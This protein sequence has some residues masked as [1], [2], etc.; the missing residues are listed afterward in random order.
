MNQNPSNIDT[1]LYFNYCNFKLHTYIYS[2]LFANMTN[3]RKYEY[4]FN[5]FDVPNDVCIS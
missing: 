4:I 2:I 1:L 3:K 5:F